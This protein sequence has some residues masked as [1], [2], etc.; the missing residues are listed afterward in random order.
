MYTV[1]D[2]ANWFLAKNTGINSKKLNLLLYY[3]YAWYLALENESP[4]ELDT[5]FFPNEFEAWI[6]GAVYP[7][8][9]RTYSNFAYFDL[10]HYTGDLP[11][12]SPDEADILEQVWNEYGKYT[13]DE[14]ESICQQEAP[15]LNARD[16]YGMWE[17]C[18]NVLE[19]KDIF[20]CYAARI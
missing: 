9:M 11:H 6:H 2:I 8:I 17:P 19:D 12:F 7:E 18:E 10:P 5:R 20:L 16:G 3:A 4:D 13:A 15:W 1:D 14:L